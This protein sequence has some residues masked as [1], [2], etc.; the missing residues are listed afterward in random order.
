LESVRLLVQSALPL[1]PNETYSVGAP[2]R[3]TDGPLAGA[4]GRITGLTK[5]RLVVTITLL[6][7]SISVELR[8]DWITTETSKP[9]GQYV[10]RAGIGC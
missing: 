10:S 2:I 9:Y 3:V 8:P 4:Q 5:Q 6:Q 1:N 7:R